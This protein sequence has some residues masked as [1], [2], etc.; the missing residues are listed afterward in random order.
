[1]H[2]ILKVVRGTLSISHYDKI[3]QLSL[4][5]QRLIPSTLRNRLDLIER[6]IFVPVS[7][8]STDATVTSTSSPIILSPYDGNYH[9][10]CNESDDPAAFV[11]ILSPP[12]NHKGFELSMDGDSVVRECEYF[13]EV[14]FHSN[15]AEEDDHTIIKWL[16]MI[17]APPDFTCDSEPYLGPTIEP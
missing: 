5:Q 9:K 1:M 12:Y 13:K 15:N 3:P 7:T 4:S 2:G 14:T 17:H 10:L 16:K 8:I 11:D 6:G